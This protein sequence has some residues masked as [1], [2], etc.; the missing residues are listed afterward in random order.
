MPE[1]HLEGL[2]KLMTRTALYL[3]L[4]LVPCG[5]AAAQE[6][7]EE[8]QRQGQGQRNQLVSHATVQPNWIAGTSRFWYRSELGE[9]KREFV[10]VDPK[11]PSRKPA[12]DHAKL[13]AA[14]AKPLGHDV[15][16][17]RLPIDRMAFGGDLSTVSVQIGEKA[18]EVNLSTYE[19]KD[20]APLPAP[21][22]APPFGGR[23]GGDVAPRAAMSR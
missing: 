23:R 7:P 13:A 2:P 1:L 6:H 4:F 10:L 21:P 22:A 9:G 12:F 19:L 8:T 11:V 20:A 14:L 5:T 15:P 17:D 3:L 18:F 16:A